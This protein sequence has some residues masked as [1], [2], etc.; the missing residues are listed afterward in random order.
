MSLVTWI[1]IYFVLWW[2]VL[3]AVLPWGAHPPEEVEQ[4]M[5]DSAPAAPRLGLKF[6][7]TTVVS[8]AILGVA[9]LVF[10]TGIISFRDFMRP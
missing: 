7:V 6:A 5:A 1:A 3:F 2:V 8:A 9:Y 10:A 4:G